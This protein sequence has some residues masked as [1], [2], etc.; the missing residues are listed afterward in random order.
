MEYALPE[1]TIGEKWQ[2]VWN[3]VILSLMFLMHKLKFF[4]LFLLEKQGLEKFKFQTIICI[5]QNRWIKRNF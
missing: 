2:C 5:I 1:A 4:Y 3:G